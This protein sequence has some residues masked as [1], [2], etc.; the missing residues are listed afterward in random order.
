MKT[1]RHAAPPAGHRQRR[2]LERRRLVRQAAALVLLVVLL[3]ALLL[4]GLQWLDAG[5]S[6]LSLAHIT[7]ITLDRLHGGIT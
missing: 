5:S 6:G 1:A 7:P 4:L 3:V 2:S